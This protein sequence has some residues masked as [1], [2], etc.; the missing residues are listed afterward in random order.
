MDGKSAMEKLMT[1]PTKS[2]SWWLDFN[3][4]VILENMMVRLKRCCFVNIKKYWNG[5]SKCGQ[6]TWKEEAISMDFR[7][8]WTL[9][10]PFFTCVQ[11]KATLQETKLIYLC[12]IMWKFRTTGLISS[13]TLVLLSTS[14][15]WTE[16][17]WLH[18]EMECVP[19]RN[20]LDQSEKCSRQR[21][22]ILANTFPMLSS[23]TNSVPA[24]CTEKWYIPKLKKFFIKWPC[25]TWKQCKRTCC[26]RND[27]ST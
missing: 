4:K 13:I 11:F 22:S 17:V 19:E 21:I 12:K 27:D 6:T 5:R 18:D 26:T 7:V 20:M 1:W 15:L 23:L 24:D 16:Q 9:T 8:A 25:T 10:V 14:I 3:I 2:R